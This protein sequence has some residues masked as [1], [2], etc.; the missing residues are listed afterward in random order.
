V[1]SLLFNGFQIES[2]ETKTDAVP[3]RGS[4]GNPQ[5][6]GGFSEDD[7]NHGLLAELADALDSKSNVQNSQSLTPSD[8]TTT[9]TENLAPG[10]PLAGEKQAEIDAD[11]A[12]IIDAW[13]ALPADVR[14]M[15]VG[16]VKATM[17]KGKARR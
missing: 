10:L 8:V 4:V 9:A 13:P 14:R 2:G 5:E 3:S 11:L 12:A 16:V 1:R 15:I 17:E 6:S 7:L